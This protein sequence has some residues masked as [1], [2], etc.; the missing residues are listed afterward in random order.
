MNQGGQEGP[1]RGEGEVKKFSPQT[2]EDRRGPS[3]KLFSQN[4]NF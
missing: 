4:E 1:K 2:P 3:Y